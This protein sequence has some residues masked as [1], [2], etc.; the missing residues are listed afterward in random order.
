MEDTLYK[1][2]VLNIIQVEVDML[3]EE[4]MMEA[5]CYAD[6]DEEAYRNKYLCLRR[7][8]DRLKSLSSTIHQTHEP[9]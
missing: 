7:T 1:S 6:T 2:T 9:F 3:H 5:K 4:M 8:M